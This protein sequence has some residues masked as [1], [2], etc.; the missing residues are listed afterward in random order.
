MM[1]CGNP[2][3]LSKD[4]VEAQQQ[5]LGPWVKRNVP[6]VHVPQRWAETDPAVLREKAEKRIKAMVEAAK[7]IDNPE[8]RDKLLSQAKAVQRAGKKAYNRGRTGG[9]KRDVEEASI[10]DDVK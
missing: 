8:R 1:T 6:C 4:P 2:S 3:S 7:R 5:R 10:V 9:R